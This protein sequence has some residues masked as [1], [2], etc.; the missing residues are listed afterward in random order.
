MRADST[1]TGMS[2][3]RYSAVMMTLLHRQ[4]SDLSHRLNDRLNDG[5]NNFVPNT[6]AL[7]APVAEGKQLV[8]QPNGAV[9]ACG[10]TTQMLDMYNSVFVQRLKL[11]EQSNG[12][13]GAS[14][15]TI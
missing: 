8:R 2:A 3:I 12:P 11:V 4:L 14:T 6:G 13:V 9:G 5:L 15:R 10:R 7:C 1:N